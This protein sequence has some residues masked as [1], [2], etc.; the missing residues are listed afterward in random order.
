MSKAIS[1]FLAYAPEDAQMAAKLRKHLHVLEES[2]QIC[3]WDESQIKPGEDVGQASLE[4]IKKADAVVF[5]LSADFI[6]SDTGERFQQI[7]LAQHG[8]KGT[9]VIPVYLRACLLDASWENFRIVPENRHAIVSDF[10]A[11]TDEALLQVS[12]YL[13]D[14]LTTAS[15]RRWQRV[16]RRNSLLG[17]GALYTL[18]AGLLYGLFI[19]P[20]HSLDVV[21]AH[22]SA[23]RV[24]FDVWHSPAGPLLT[25]L[26]LREM[27]VSHFQQIRL[28]AREIWVS[29]QWDEET[30][31]P[32]GWKRMSANT[33]TVLPRFGES[34]AIFAPV[35]LKALRAAAQP[36][37]T[38]L[39]IPE[40]EEGDAVKWLK[41]GIDVPEGNP[42]ALLSFGDTL[43]LGVN[44]CQIDGINDPVLREA[45]AELLLVG[46]AETGGETV[47]GK[48]QGFAM[49]LF[50]ENDI[51]IREANLQVRNLRF[52]KDIPGSPL[53][54]LYG[55]SIFLSETAQKQN[56]PDITLDEGDCLALTE[57]S[58]HLSLSNIRI[59][60][61]R[62]ELNW[63]GSV[64]NLETGK[65][66][67]HLKTRLPSRLEWVLNNKLTEFVLALIA[68]SGFTVFLYL[69]R[70]RV[71]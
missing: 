22:L 43:R 16:L 57:N 41:T 71:R 9:L 54:S 24:E 26:R 45:S 34:S 5:L 19:S 12:E 60:P 30:D 58:G 51:H 59:T 47:T 37:H 68:L 52:V 32:V 13:K 17:L 70:I 11:N 63:A 35:S 3:L 66:F 28:E 69:K 40:S 50:F 39:A 56:R 10:W 65:D 2:G 1:V 18:V 29:T 25:N 36:A 20:V 55:G 21:A 42:Q 8:A 14:A 46:P 27:G 53:S 67:D 4:Q 31:E 23:S 44:N 15:K 48:Q 64:R 49:D 38:V 61:E 62:I 7:A 33:L 6:A